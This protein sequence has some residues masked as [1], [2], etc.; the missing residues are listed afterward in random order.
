MTKEKDYFRTF[1]KVSKAFGTTLSSKKLLDLIVQSAIET[2]D[3]KAAC[4]FLAEQDKDIFV[5]VAQKGLSDSY[6]HQKPMKARRIVDKIIEGGY[7]YFR[8]ATTDPRLEHHDAKK[9]EG[10]A[11]IL[12]VP[13][14]VRNRTMGILSLYTADTRDYS[15]DDIDFLAALAEQGGIAIEHARL[16]DRI[17][18]NAT[19][20]LDLAS[21]INS[22]LD[23]KKILN[24]LTVDICEALGMKAAAIRLLD[25][26]SGDLK[27]V[28]SHGLS[29]E[30]LNKG[31]VSATTS[32]TQALKGETLVIEDA[33]K[34]ERIQY[35][36]EMKKEG[37]I[38]MIVTPIKSRDQIIGV[39]RLYANVK[40]EFPEDFI[41][42]VK[43]LAHQGA[44]A[45]QNA[46]MYLAL[47]KDKEDL[48]QDIWSHRSWF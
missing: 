29:D 30:F 13:V 28:A 9:A 41:T 36:K 38:S 14:I 15:E 20:F 17:Q 4:L 45:I 34:D 21:D 42:M 31:P 24:N 22:S 6:L 39:L 7:L 1:C 37:I 25:R 33:T 16:L 27:L 5:P 46:T 18:K 47:Q 8:D 35:K 43:A 10:I 26:N 3:A 11:T 23:I 44:L 19:L 2:M 12:S 40:R 32:A 48:E